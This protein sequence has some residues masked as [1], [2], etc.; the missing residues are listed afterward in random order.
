MLE[1]HRK[2][3]RLHHATFRVRRVNAWLGRNSLGKMLLKRFRSSG[4]S[5]RGARCRSPAEIRQ[6]F[7]GALAR[8]HT[9]D[10]CLQTRRAPPPQPQ[11]R[12]AD[13]RSPPIMPAFQESAGAESLLHSR[14]G[15]RSLVL[16]RGGATPV[17]DPMRGATARFCRIGCPSTSRARKLVLERRID[18]LLRHSMSFRSRKKVGL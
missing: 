14:A 9:C 6:E 7:S 8:F 2:C 3:E 18:A 4:K 13:A 11:L 10:G 1:R 17:A 15:G 5:P 12:G 16:M